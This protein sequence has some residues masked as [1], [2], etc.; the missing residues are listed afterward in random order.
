MTGTSDAARATT[1]R[2]VGLTLLAQLTV[3]AVLFAGG[4][5]RA[6]AYLGFVEQPPAPT[7][8]WMLALA[9]VV[10][11]VGSAA[12]ISTVRETLF[13]LDRLKALCIAAAL[14]AG[15]VEEVVFRKLL[16][17]FLHGQGAG[18]TVQITASALAF[19]LAHI[20]WGLKSRAAAVNAV[21]STT[22]LGAALAIVYL[23]AAR[24]LA[25]CVV[26]H[27]LITALIEPGLIIAGVEDRLGFWRER[28]N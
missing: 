15:I 16:R 2:I 6:P 13:R 12:T 1:R 11:Y 23:A 14:A 5:A 10:A 24:N 7:L 28:R 25:P 26:A 19:G 22:L 18:L 21:L 20:V 9:T 4:P 27:F 8:A 17:D 3:L